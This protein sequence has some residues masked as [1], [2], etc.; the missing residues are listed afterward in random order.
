VDKSE[1]LADLR[2]QF[3]EKKSVLYADELAQVLGKSTKAIYDLK[4]RGGLP[5][6][7]LPGE[8]RPCVSIHAVADW[9]A[10]GSSVAYPDREAGVSISPAAKLPAPKPKKATHQSMAA[11]L[12]ALRGQMDFLH[13]LH[14]EMEGIIIAEESREAAEGEERGL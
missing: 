3:G 14:S 1:I 12:S 2:Q 7:V 10:G 4:N 6:P 5:V 13:Q 11:Y 9:L 8:G